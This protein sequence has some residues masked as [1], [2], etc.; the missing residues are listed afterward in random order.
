MNPVMNDSGSDERSPSPEEVLLREVNARL[1]AGKVGLSVI[2]I[3]KKLYLQGKM[4]DPKNP[5]MMKRRQLPLKINASIAGIQ[6]AEEEARRISVQIARGQ[7]PEPTYKDATG[8][9]EKKLGD[10]IASWERAYRKRRGDKFNPKTWA[11]DYAFVYSKLDRDRIWDDDYLMEFI[12]RGT[13]AGTRSRVRFVNAIRALA[14]HAGRDIDFKGMNSGYE[15][16]KVARILPDDEDIVK[17]WKQVRDMGMSDWAWV[18][19]AIATYGLRPHE[20]YRL[21]TTVLESGE[22]KSIRVTE[23]SKTGERVVWP[24]WPDWVEKFGLQDVRIPEY[25]GD[26]PD[27]NEILGHKVTLKFTRNIGVPFKLYNL[28]HKYAV[29]CIAF[30]VNDTMAARWMGHSVDVHRKTYQRWLS[31]RDQK[32]EFERLERKRGGI[33]GAS[34]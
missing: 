25:D 14:R 10:W 18:L 21:D 33:Q 23:N 26:N 7:Q 30:E 4:P 13:D 6:V 29:R 32:A 19:G 31:A 9:G 5:G 17:V 34:G 12:E 3:K 16:Q 8:G 22:D 28:R 15:A 11:K 24:V 2:R 27:D 1:K 20:V